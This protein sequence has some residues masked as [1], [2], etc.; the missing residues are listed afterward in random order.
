[1]EKSNFI[2]SAELWVE[3]RDV[4]NRIVHDYLPNQIEKIYAQIQTS[5]FA[6]LKRFQLSLLAISNE[7]N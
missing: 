1:M 4:R 7:V 3:M 5:Y 6:E 2:S